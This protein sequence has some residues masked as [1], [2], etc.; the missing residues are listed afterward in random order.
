MYR[1]RMFVHPSRTSGDGNREGVP[2]S[3]LEAMASGAPVVATRHGGIPEAVTDG[4][5]GL[6][7]PENDAR[8]LAAAM[9]RVMGEDG[10]ARKL[11]AGG[12]RA[13]EERF[14]RVANIRV[15]ESCYL[16]LIAA[17]RTGA[18]TLFRTAGCL[19]RNS[20]SLVCKGYRCHHA[21]NPSRQCR[22]QHG[23]FAV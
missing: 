20:R 22:L 3:M 13:V 7:V 18:V 11:A 19:P 5:S 17:D 14:D 2:N 12:R 4:A 16:D 1:A 9:L 6:L 23:G 21:E 10:L 15:L 8:A